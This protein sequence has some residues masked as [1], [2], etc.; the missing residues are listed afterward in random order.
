MKLADWTSDPLPEDAAHA[1]LVGRI[2]NPAVEGPCVV[3]LDGADVID[4]TAAAA[5][6]RDLC[7]TDGPCRFCSRRR[8][9]AGRSAQRHSGKHT[10]PGSRR[11]ETMAH[12]AER[13]AGDQ[14]GGRDLRRLHAGA[15]DRGAGARRGGARRRNPRR[16][17]RHDRRRPSQAEA[18][19]GAGDGAE[20][21][22]DREGRLVAISRSRHRA[23]R[24]G[25]H[26]GATDVGGRA[27]RRSGAA[28][29]C[30][31]GTIRSRRSCSSFRAPARSSA[32][33]SATTST[34]ATSKGA[35]RS[36]S[37]RP[38]TTMRAPRSGRSSGFSTRISRSMSCAARS[39]A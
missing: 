18:R 11:D 15:R 38:R 22:P 25:L 13:P 3:R 5:T 16:D 31:R 4:I 1:T 20:G 6:M 17:Q 8:G 12:R 21:A 23:G 34:S 19:L 14:G 29:R 9:P 10:A 7:E 36:S 35:P 28:T 24:R 2:W 37:A 39:F 32:R 30:R 26:Q 27:S 33:R